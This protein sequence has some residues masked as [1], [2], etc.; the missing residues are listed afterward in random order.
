[1][2]SVCLLSFPASAQTD[3][4]ASK[5]QD[6]KTAIGQSFNAVL[7]AEKA[8][9]NV[10]NLLSQLND[11]DSVLAQAEN[12]YRNGDSTKA[13]IQADSV[14]PLAQQIT[15]SAESAKQSAT[16][17]AQ[18]AWYVTLASTVIGSIVFLLVLFMVWRFVKRR[19]VDNLS[20]A[21]PELVNQ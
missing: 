3:Q 6:A 5:L 14:L 7:A 17:K 19:Y 18:N 12:S 10:D 13:G 2:L 4:T 20:D 8:G 16:V 21:K 15:V 11:A 9:A 1:M